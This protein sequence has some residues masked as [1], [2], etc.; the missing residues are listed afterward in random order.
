L[1]AGRT[2][3]P[4]CGRYGN[5]AHPKSG[6]RH[7][8]QYCSQSEK[9]SWH[10]RIERP[11]PSAPGQGRSLERPTEIAFS[12]WAAH[13]WRMD[14]R[15]AKVPTIASQFMQYLRDGGWVKASAAAASAR[16]IDNLLAKGWVERRGLG[17]ELF[18]RLTDDGPAAKKAPPPVQM[19]PKYPARKTPD[20]NGNWF[21]CAIVDRPFLHQRLAMSLDRS[22][23]RQMENG[24]P[25][26]SP[27]LRA[28]SDQHS[29]Q[30]HELLSR[31]IK[32]LEQRLLILRNFDA[33]CSPAKKLPGA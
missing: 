32:I 24:R 5:G 7:L 19:A 13:L 29:D 22:G 1:L 20:V 26:Q 10:E 23:R 31:R 14:E 33:P 12:P 2:R 16:P 25:R 27:D 17:N 28:V 9:L 30:E 6:P 4:S 15:G 11:A 3:A 8:N 18:Y 21:L